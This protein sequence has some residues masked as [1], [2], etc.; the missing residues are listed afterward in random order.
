MRGVILYG[1]PAAGKD[2]VTRALH[3]IDPRYLQF[4]RLKVG[5]GR[6]FGYRM[7]TVEHINQIRGS[8][9][10]IWENRRYEALY[11]VD[12]AKLEADLRNHKPVLH[13]GQIEA[14]QAIRSS[15]PGT[16]WLTVYLYCDRRV[17]RRRIDA[18]I[19]GDTEAR[20]RAWDETPPLMNADLTV[21]TGSSEPEEV[22]RQIHKAMTY[23]YGCS[24][25]PY[26]RSPSYD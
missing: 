4:R 6:T 1:P 11:V 23:P 8:G 24:S 10:V 26:T 22:A 20:L 19:T 13:L 25:P 15:L 18:R 21:D 2:T 12:R 14:V 9:D 3:A 7:T 17:A 16:C 5:P